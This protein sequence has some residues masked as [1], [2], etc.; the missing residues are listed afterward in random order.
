MKFLIIEDSMLYQKFIVKK[1]KENFT[2]AVYLT[3]NSGEEGYQKYLEEKPDFV[4]L[5]LLLPDKKGQDVLK[6]IYEYNPN[7]K[8]IVISADVQNMV[9]KEVESIG[10]LNFFNKPLTDDKVE[11]LVKIIEENYDA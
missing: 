6:S 9:R 7:V 4:L 11:D 8:V 2:D 5:D 3:A 10:I 1:L